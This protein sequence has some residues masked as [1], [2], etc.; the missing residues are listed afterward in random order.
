MISLAAPHIVGNAKKY[1][2]DCIDTGWVSYAGEYVTRLEEMVAKYVGTKYAV[3][4]VSGT[5]ALEVALRAAG[6]G[7]GDSV[8]VPTITFIATAAAVKHLGANPIFLD[9][10]KYG[11]MS[12]AGLYGYLRYKCLKTEHGLMAADGSIIKA[13]VPVH[14]FGVLCD[15]QRICTYAKAFDIPVIEDACEALGSRFNNNVTKF[16]Y[17]A[18]GSIGLLGCFS[19]S[20]NKTVTSSGG[21]MVV[22]DNKQLADKIRYWTTTA[23]DDKENYI[24]NEVGYN[25]RMTNIAAAIGVSQMELID[26]FIA[27]KKRRFEIYQDTFKN[28]DNVQLIRPPYDTD[29]NYWFY[30]LW[31]NGLSSKAF[32]MP[33]QVLAQ[34]LKTKGIQTR[35]V[36]YPNHLQVP[37]RNCITYEI[38]YAYEF[39]RH[40]LNIPCG[41]E[42]TDEDV[43]KVANTIQEYCKWS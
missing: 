22:T 1:V 32:D 30:G 6:V 23:N 13:I 20:F 8:I 27:N 17:K 9:C 25:Y 12:A 19:F 18:G 35:P 26:E 3:A 33:R 16:A 15:M 7:P 36:W 43:Y 5:S 11:N 42:L 21:G 28:L 24:H 31:V 29:S 4:T 41:N 39:H 34:H 40:V 37:Y 2:N 14:I 38:N 10:N